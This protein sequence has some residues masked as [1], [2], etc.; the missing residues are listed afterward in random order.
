MLTITYTNSNGTVK[1]QGG[2]ASSP[3]RITEI[4]GLGLTEREYSVAVYANYDGQNTFNSRAVARTITIALEL[5]GKDISAIIRSAINVFSKSGTL[6]ITDEHTDRKITCHQVQMPEL[7]RVLKG[8]ILA[9]VIQFVCDSPFFEDAEDSILPLYQREKLISSPFS[10]PCMFGKIT[11]GANI[12]IRGGISVEPIISIYCPQAFEGVENIIVSNETTGKVIKLDYAP[13]D[14]EKIVIDVK[15]RKITSSKNGNI[16][17]YLTED[18]FIGDFVLAPGLNILTVNIGDTTS[19]F[20]IECQYNNLYN[21][22][23]II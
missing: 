4:D 10:L 3:L 13:S 7:S 6:R 21:E 2:G 12:E 11:A 15:N 8:Q 23:V 22:A 18:T 19:G 14:N 5:C 17:N 20:A 16:I 1:M 9:F